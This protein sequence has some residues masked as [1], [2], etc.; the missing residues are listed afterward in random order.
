MF[1]QVFTHVTA[2]TRTTPPRPSYDLIYMK[3]DIPVEPKETDVTWLEYGKCKR[4]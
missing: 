4:M 2:Q 3:M 1:Y